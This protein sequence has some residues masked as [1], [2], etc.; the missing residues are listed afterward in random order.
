LR[1]RDFCSTF[2][3]AVAAVFPITSGLAV[4]LEHSRDGNA[5]NAGNRPLDEGRWFFSNTPL[6]RCS[7]RR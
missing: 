6:Q 2:L 7:E 3:P 1:K 4:D 5:G